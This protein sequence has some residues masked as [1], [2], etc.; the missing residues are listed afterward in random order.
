MAKSKKGGKK[1]NK[2][3][4]EHNPQTE[5][6]PDSVRGNIA[7]LTTEVKTTNSLLESSA[8]YSMGQT[9]ALQNINN[10]LVDMYNDVHAIHELMVG[11]SLKQK[12]A[13]AERQKMMEDLIKSMNKKPEKEKTDKKGDFSWLGLAASLVAGLVA[14]GIAFIKNYIKGLEVFWTAMAKAFKVDGII[15]KLFEVVKHSFLGLLDA[16]KDGF[17]MAKSFVK[18]LFKEMKWLETVREFFSGIGKYFVKIFNL[19][20]IGKDFEALWTSIKGVWEM[21]GKPLKF[22]GEIFGG[23][24]GGL[25]SYF[26]DLL[27][28]F[29]PLFGFFKSLGA[30]LGKLAVPLQVIMSVFDT[31][32]G[33]LD[34]WNKT[35][36]TFM[37]KLT[38]AIKGGLT[39]L[40]N[41]LI[42]GL[43]DLLKD[44]L[45][46]ILGFF[47][48]KDAAAWLDSFSFTDIITKGVGAAIDGMIQMFKDMLAAPLAIFQSAKDLAAGKIDWGTFFKQA[49]A[50][51]IT[52]LL[53]PVNMISKWAG[54]DLTKKALEMLG[55]N[56]S[57]GGTP[58][59]APAPAAPPAAAQ[60]AAA[61]P[62]EVPKMLA[63]V[64]EAPKAQET[65]QQAQ[66]RLD[67]AVEE[68]QMSKADANVEKMKLGLRPSFG[69]AGSGPKDMSAP[70]IPISSSSTRW[71]PEDAMAR[72]AQ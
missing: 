61:P 29:K 31:V 4:G 20:E 71:D 51:L 22:L 53:A 3:S 16:F 56:G 27:K 59:A 32:S 7:A 9:F 19:G 69:R 60:A 37:D 5:G 23:G 21:M 30:I 38:G 15:F 12:E 34:G 26:D 40:L 2:G 13:D 64:A 50:G 65:L 57:G 42:G 10:V 18:G 24:G 45:S 1:S 6:G 43:L 68:G 70:A 8:D 55:L 17:N 39:G 72:G 33:A 63:K 62:A 41:G 25:L 35:E 58:E 14:G 49:L 28:F 52:A 36:G 66:D 46:F 48:M 11:N 44:G 67:K 47:G 54:F